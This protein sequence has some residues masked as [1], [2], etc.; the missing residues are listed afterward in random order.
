MEPYV[1]M[2]QVD[3][4]LQRKCWQNLKDFGNGYGYLWIKIMFFVW[5]YNEIWDRYS[6][7]QSKGLEMR[8]KA[9]T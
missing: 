2:Y 1:S 8:S 3:P 4:V 6:W 9:E 7:Y 5:K